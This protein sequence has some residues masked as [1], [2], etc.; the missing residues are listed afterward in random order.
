[1]PTA[2]DLTAVLLIA[3]SVGCAPAPA[4]DATPSVDQLRAWALG[5][6][7]PAGA[8]RAAVERIVA[9]RPDD[10]LAARRLLLAHACDTRD[11]P[12]ALRALRD[13][14]TYHTD[15]LSP[16]LYADA[17]HRIADRTSRGR[18]DA[19]TLQRALEILHQ[20]VDD[21]PDSLPLRELR[22]RLVDDWAQAKAQE[23]HTRDADGTPHEYRILA[24]P[25]DADGR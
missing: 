20:G 9:E 8:V 11:A 10:A 25:A 18:R 7:P 23:M 24:D 12:G 1:M 4:E 2:K 3:L 14:G 6:H 13:L 21:F 15:A 17:A 22:L 19:K 16:G 5:E